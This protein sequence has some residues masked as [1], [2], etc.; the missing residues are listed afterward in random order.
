MYVMCVVY[1]MCTRCVVYVK[2]VSCVMYV[3]CVSCV[4]YICDVCEYT[5]FKLGVLC[6]L[7]AYVGV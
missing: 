2:S 6:I 1:V 3:E 5:Y 7:L 4:V